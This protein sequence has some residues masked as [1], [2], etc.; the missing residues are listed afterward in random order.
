M[1]K[2]PCLKKLLAYEKECNHFS[3]THSFYSGTPLVKVNAT[4]SFSFHVLL[5]FSKGN[6]ECVLPQP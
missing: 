1:E 2:C 5:E 4:C 3:P 6:L